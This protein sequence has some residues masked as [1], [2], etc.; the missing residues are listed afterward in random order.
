MFSISLSL[1]IQEFSAPHVEV[2]SF[3]II[4]RFLRE[5]L[6][7]RLREGDLQS[8]GDLLRN[9]ILDIKYVLHQTVEPFG[10]EV[11]TISNVDELCG[12]ADLI[13]RFSNTSLQHVMLV[14]KSPLLSVPL[15]A[16]ALSIATSN[17]TT[18]CFAAMAL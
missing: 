12:D 10:P 13:T 7:L 14:F 11:I 15:T 6:S 2:I 3:Q 18:S 9:F 1:R 5:Q 4:R 8:I 17:L 16:S